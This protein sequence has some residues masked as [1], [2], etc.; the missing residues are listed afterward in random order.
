MNEK[1]VKYN[2]KRGRRLFW[3]N[4][5]AFNYYYVAAAAGWDDVDRV[6]A[7][8]SVNIFGGLAVDNV[9]D[10]VLGTGDLGVY[11]QRGCF[12][13]VD[14]RPAILL[15]GAFHISGR[16]VCWDCFYKWIENRG[17]YVS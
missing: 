17:L 11:P 4:S 16:G 5:G 6:F 10:I 15:R 7:N 2:I 12:F 13:C 3:L 9:R 8:L 14:K 1:Q